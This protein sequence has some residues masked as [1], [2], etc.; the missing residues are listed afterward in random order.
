[1]TFSWECCY[2]CTMVLVDLA[3]D[4]PGVARSWCA[5]GKMVSVV[6]ED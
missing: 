1:M 4:E 6:E 3:S 5:V 2:G